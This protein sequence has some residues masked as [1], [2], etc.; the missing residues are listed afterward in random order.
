MPSSTNRN[1]GLRPL[2]ASPLKRR[3]VRTWRM[4]HGEDDGMMYPLLPDDAILWRRLRYVNAH[5]VHDAAEA[6]VGCFTVTVQ[7]DGVATGGVAV[8]RDLRALGF[9]SAI[10]RIQEDLARK[11][12]AHSFR[13][14]VFDDNSAGVALMRTNGYRP[15]TWFE[16]PLLESTAPASPRGSGIVNATTSN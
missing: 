16:K 11:L 5:L 14:D 9:G 13:C 1:A 4:L 7:L 6:L 15:F 2:V 3:D 8:K 10:L 12:G